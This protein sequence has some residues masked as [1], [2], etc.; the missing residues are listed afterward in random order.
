MLPFAQQSYI[1]QSSSLLQTVL[2][3]QQIHSYTTAFALTAVQMTT[4]LVYLQKQ[5]QDLVCTK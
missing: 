4:A 3:V 1:A 5:A 2:V